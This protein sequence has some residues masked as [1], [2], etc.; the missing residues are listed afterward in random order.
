MFRRRLE[1]TWYGGNEQVTSESPDPL[2][3]QFRL[4]YNQRRHIK[5]RRGKVGLSRQAMLARR[6]RIAVS[7]GVGVG[8]TADASPRSGALQS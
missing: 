5:P 6:R 8:S 3:R 1:P 2:S 7:S 4:A